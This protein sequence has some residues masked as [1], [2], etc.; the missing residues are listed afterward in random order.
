MTA[1]ERK[2]FDNAL[3][4]RHY[5]EHDLNLCLCAYDNFKVEKLDFCNHIN[6]LCK[7]HND[8]A[9]FKY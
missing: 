3:G 2:Q 5:N 6:N 7:K 4:F 1:G 8:M 9:L